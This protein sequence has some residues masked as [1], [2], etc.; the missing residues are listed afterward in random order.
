MMAENFAA[1][2]R[3]MWQSVVALEE[4][5]DMADKLAADVEPHLRAELLSEARLARER[6]AVIRG[7]LDTRM[8]F[9]LDPI[10]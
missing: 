3:T 10:G 6:A 8:S 9:D 4:G 7:M 5:A 2:E 1:Q